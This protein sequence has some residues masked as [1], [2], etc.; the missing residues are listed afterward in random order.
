M[1]F[2]LI[3]YAKQLVNNNT[4]Y[5]DK[6]DNKFKKLN[7][8]RCLDNIDN[9]NG[10]RIVEDQRDMKQFNISGYKTEK[11]LSNIDINI[12]N[13]VTN[14]GEKLLNYYDNKKSVFS[15]Q[16]CV[17]PEKELFN[18][19]HNFIIN[20]KIEYNN[21]NNNANHNKKNNIDM[22]FICNFIIIINKLLLNA[23]LGYNFQ[24]GD[25]VS[26]TKHR[27]TVYKYDNSSYS[28]RLPLNNNLFNLL[29]RTE[30][31]LFFICKPESSLVLNDNPLTIEG[32]KKL[33]N[34]K[35]KLFD[36]V[37]N[38]SDIDNLVYISGSSESAITTASFLAVTDSIFTDNRLDIHYFNKIHIIYYLRTVLRLCKEKKIRVEELLNYF[39]ELRDRISYSIEQDDDDNDFMNYLTQKEYNLTELY[40]F[41]ASLSR[42]L[43]ELL[44]K[45]EYSDSFKTYYDTKFNKKERKDLFNFMNI[46]RCA[47]Q[48]KYIRGV[49]SK[50]LDKTELSTRL[51]TPSITSN[52][53]QSI[54]IFNYSVYDATG[55]QDKDINKDNIATYN[56][57]LKYY[58]N[59]DE[60]F[61]TCDKENYDFNKIIVKIIINRMGWNIYILLIICKYIDSQI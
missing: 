56:G 25:I 36:I 3:N 47:K 15:N 50:V 7:I 9:F 45:P 5:I 1:K 8:M 37:Y 20:N 13:Y 44:K 4:T 21:A 33:E 14:Q 53:N 24:E 43:E 52:S 28:R 11:K 42:F 40:K 12:L 27:L 18:E 41:P 34:I 31:T 6:Y 26:M 51:L 48:P 54:Q 59:K 29:S 22:S 16:K 46:I 55:N 39:D 23:C 32:F 38:T 35:N 49:Y 17:N 10:L 2:F 57:L 60:K 30:N 61:L 19:I 58:F